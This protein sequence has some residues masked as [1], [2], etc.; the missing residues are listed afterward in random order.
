MS[1][2]ENK[3]F[4]SPCK[5]E[6]TK[7][8][9]LYT[10]IYDPT[11]ILKKLAENKIKY[12]DLLFDEKK[13]EVKDNNGSRCN[14]ISISLYYTKN[15]DKKLALYLSAIK[16]SVLNVENNLPEWIVRIYMDKSV[17][18]A[19]EN[20]NTEVDNALES[21]N[22]EKDNLNF[23]EKHRETYIKVLDF[24]KNNKQVEIYTYSCDNVNNTNISR[25]RIYRFFPLIDPNV[26]ISIIR[27]ADGIVTNLDCYNI[28]IFEQSDKLLYIVPLMLEPYNN[29]TKVIGKLFDDSGNVITASY[30]RWLI[31]YKMSIDEPEDYFE[32]KNNIYDLLAGCF[33]CK[34]KIKS[35]KFNS[36]YKFIS[37]K[38]SKRKSL[39]CCNIGFDEMLLLSLF[40][41]I[42]SVDYKYYDS[43][44]KYD[45]KMLMKYDQ[46]MLKNVKNIIHGHH[47]IIEYKW[48]EETRKILGIQDKYN[49]ILNNY[50]T[51]MEKY[52]ESIIPDD[53]HKIPYELYFIDSLLKN[54]KVDN[55]ADMINIQNITNVNEWPQTVFDLLNFEFRPLYEEIYHLEDN[56][57]K[58]DMNMLFGGDYL[59]YNKIKKDYIKLKNQYIKYSDTKL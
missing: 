58:L 43:E 32:E 30:Q 29:K 14:C 6:S 31:A 49:N 20:K 18:D 35:N 54:I 56:G 52:N 37:D 9:S 25:T 44:N 11:K 33:G 53:V 34:L 27:E 2:V 39:H 50:K 1:E 15:F 10:K 26:N 12:G 4:C 55:N 21:K 57:R 51:I 5:L 38:I 28:K 22:T 24:L 40:K 3:L 19:I 41:D 45:Q 7:R 46:E 23:I 42:V 48:N 16:R 17:Y 8:I 36:V 59:K 13:D 47:N